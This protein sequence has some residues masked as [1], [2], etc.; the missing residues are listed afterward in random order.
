MIT[1]APSKEITIQLMPQTVCNFELFFFITPQTAI[2]GE[3]KKC[4]LQYNNK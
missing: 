4:V 1:K 3:K 2:L